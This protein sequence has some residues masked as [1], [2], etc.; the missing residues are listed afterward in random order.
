MAS[1]MGTSFLK[2]S[3]PLPRLPT[4]VVEVLAPC[5]VVPLFWKP[6]FM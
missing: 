1:I 6:V 2:L 3:L 4:G 5:G